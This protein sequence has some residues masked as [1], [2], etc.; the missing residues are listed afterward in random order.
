MVTSS[1]VN[2]GDLI[3]SE[4]PF[5]EINFNLSKDNQIHSM[6]SQ[7]DLK[8][9]QEI[10]FFR[11]SYLFTKTNSKST[12]SINSEKC[13]NYCLKLTSLTSTTFNWNQQMF[14][15]PIL[16]TSESDIFGKRQQILKRLH[17]T[18]LN[19]SFLIL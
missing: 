12:N 14:F 1:A 5:I 3:Y 16:Q 13:L 10:V 19:D 6:K 8:T 11:K 7:L 2:E 15:D 17:F 9:S 4:A 18:C